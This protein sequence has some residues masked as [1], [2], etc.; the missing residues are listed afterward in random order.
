MRRYGLVLTVSMVLGACG[1]GSGGSSGGGGGG[2]TSG[3]ETSYAGAIGSTDVAHGEARYTAVCG[4]CHNN[5]APA[6]ADLAWTPERM[7]RQ[8]REGSGS[9]PAIRDTRLNA[10]DMEA[11]LAYL[12][13]INGVVDSGA[14]AGE[15]STT[16]P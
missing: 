5:G 16:A 6:V 15:A 3:G 1:G 12:A 13:S 9:M 11:V 10:E 8:I 2:G 14:V 7:R 4:S